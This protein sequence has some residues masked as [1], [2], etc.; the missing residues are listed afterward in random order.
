M[1]R[2]R[3]FSLSRYPG[4]ALL[5]LLAVALTGCATTP[6]AN[7]A[8]DRAE[9]A[10]KS[11]QSNP[12]IVANA[13][14]ALYEAR[15]A[16]DQA[17]EAEDLGEATHLAYIAEKKAQLAAEISETKM[18][19]EKLTLLGQEREQILLKA[20]E[21]EAEQ[22]RLKAELE[23]RR[24]GISRQQAQQARREA[25]MS[26]QQ[27]RL[28]REKALKAEQAA[29]ELQKELEKLKAKQTDRGYVLTLGDILFEFDKAQLLPGA[30]NTIYRLAEFLKK[31]P[32]RKVIVE[33]HTDGVGSAE[34]NLGLSQRRADSVRDALLRSGIGPDRIISKGYGKDY[35]VA[36]N[37]TEAGR[38]QNRRVEVVI[39]EESQDP[40]QLL[41]R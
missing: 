20:R 18:A 38:Q 12:D 13:P 3:I 7:D 27:A 5:I 17:K 41:R 35:P 26:L 11:A 2:I 21:H 30:M 29:Q 40:R 39:L 31:Y 9:A 33:G 10:L 37:D 6:K 19:R 8:I 14:V 25:E 23:R 28:E 34:Y 4:F 15:Q 22:A 1:K 32:E 16:L 24:S 36:S